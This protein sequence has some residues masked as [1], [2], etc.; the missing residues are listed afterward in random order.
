MG[1]QLQP[2]LG[3]NWKR[4]QTEDKA[5]L[6]I[7]VFVCLCH[8]SVTHWHPL[9]PLYAWVQDLLTGV[10]DL[11]NSTILK[12]TD[13]PSEA[14][15]V[16][17]SSAK[18]GG[19]WALLPFLGDCQLA[20]SYAGSRSCCERMSA[21]VL[22][23]PEDAAVLW[24]SIPITDFYNLS[25]LSFTMVPWDVGSGCAKSISISSSCKWDKGQG[26]YD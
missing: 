11:P 23:W 14:I 17:I 6:N 5:H 24:L 2:T 25:T 3:T 9:L 4:Q 1:I 21:V 20:G 19:S 26:K 12:K 13:F 16:S 22:S 10:K 7:S 8:L 15:S 18:S